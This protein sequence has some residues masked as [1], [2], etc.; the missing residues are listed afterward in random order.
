MENIYQE[1]GYDNR[2]EYLNSLAE[3]FGV[4]EVTVYS[5]A[6]ML[7]KIEDFDGLVTSLEDIEAGDGGW[8]GGW[9]GD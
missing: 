4:D 8:H 6:S 7:G 9:D 1:H 3:D 5:L 2:K